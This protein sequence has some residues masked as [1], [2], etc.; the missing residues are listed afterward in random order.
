MTLDVTDPANP[1]FL[2]EST[3]PDPDPISGLPYEGNAHAADFGGNG[4][5]IF[6]GDEDFS[7]AA[8]AVT[9]N[10]LSYPAGLA[11]FGPDPNSLAGSLV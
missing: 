7:D 5:Y 3:F 10:G 8:F 6:G 11:L 1:V 4:D 9:Y 2:G